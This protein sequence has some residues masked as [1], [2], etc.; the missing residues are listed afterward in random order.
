[1]EPICPKIDYTYFLTFKAQFFYSCK[2]GTCIYIVAAG[3]TRLL[4][5]QHQNEIIKIAN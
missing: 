2:D 1:M 4:R 5:I 3:R